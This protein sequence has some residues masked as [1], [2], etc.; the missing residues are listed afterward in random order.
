MR[1]IELKHAKRLTLTVLTVV[2]F[3]AGASATKI[4]A[5]N[6]GLFEVQV[7][8]DFVVMGRTYVAAKYRIGRLSPANPDTLILKSSTGKTLLIFQTYRLSSGTQ[9]EF[10]RLTF[11]RFGK[12]SFLQSITASGQSYDS[13][14][15]SI[16]SDRL[17][18]DAAPPPQIVSI[19][20]K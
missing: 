11:K 17:L 5:Q 18:Q 15:P 20:N 12:K 3:G 1:N 8:F 10:S 6:A 2:V 14:L 13:Q 16:R 9:A 4:S 19:T 7:P